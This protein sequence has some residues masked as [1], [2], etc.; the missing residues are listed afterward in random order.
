MC[1][2]MLRTYHSHVKRGGTVLY[3]VDP[4]ESQSIGDYI[5]P[6][7]FLHIHP[8]VFLKFGVSY[9]PRQQAN[10]LIYARRYS[11]AVLIQYVLKAHMNFRGKTWSI[12]KD[13][14]SEQ[15]AAAIGEQLR[16]VIEFCSERDLHCKVVLIQRTP[17]DVSGEMRL[18]SLVKEKA[19]CVVVTNPAELNLELRL[20]TAI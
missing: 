2:H 16:C 11:I 15:D 7:D 3:V 4:A 1:Y 5:S 13:K 20:S 9:S 6:S 8:H 10:P 19:E 12:C 18:A 17:S 14:L